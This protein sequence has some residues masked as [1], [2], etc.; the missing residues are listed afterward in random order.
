MPRSGKPCWHLLDQREQLSLVW[1]SWMISKDFLMPGPIPLGSSRSKSFGVDISA[2]PIA[3]FV[4]PVAASWFF[5]SLNMGKGR[6]TFFKVSLD[7][8]RSFFK[9]API[10]KFSITVKE[11]R[12]GLLE[13]EGLL[14]LI[15]WAGAFWISL[16]FS[17]HLDAPNLEMVRKNRC[18]PHNFP[19]IYLRNWHHG[20]PG[21]CHSVQKDFSAGFTS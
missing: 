3:S 11:R 6:E 20:Q 21:S 16:E 4:P 18:F 13:A 17:Q 1:I 8:L 5:R 7:F 10:S 9:K 2:R 19:F 14:L 15:F 12:G